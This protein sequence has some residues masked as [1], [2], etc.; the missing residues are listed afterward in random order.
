MSCCCCA[1][2]SPSGC[3]RAL[4][5]QLI[6]FRLTA[7]VVQLLL[8]GL[9]SIDASESLAWRCSTSP[10]NGT[11]RIDEREARELADTAVSRAG[12][13]G[14]AR[15]T[16][17][18]PLLQRCAMLLSAPSGSGTAT[19]HEESPGMALDGA[20]HFAPGTDADDKSDDDFRGDLASGDSVVSKCRRTPPL[21]SSGVASFPVE[22]VTVVPSTDG[23]LRYTACPRSVGVSP[24]S[25]AGA[26][27]GGDAGSFACAAMVLMLQELRAT[28]AGEGSV[29]CDVEDRCSSGRAACREA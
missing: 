9:A 14:G 17:T 10:E 20:P 6:V 25:T 13:D 22:D 16:S 28:G 23:S 5:G 2:F 11:G 29:V 27:E 1:A 19:R 4:S 12:R 7:A 15:M 3:S 8:N 18:R 24:A 21:S 26:I